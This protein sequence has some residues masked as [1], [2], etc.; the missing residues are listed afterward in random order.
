MPFQK[1]LADP[2]HPQHVSELRSF[3]WVAHYRKEGKIRS[4]G[5][6]TWG[7]FRVPPENAG[8][9]ALQDVVDVAVKAG[10][11]QHGFR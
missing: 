11:L 2:A 7:C 10:G 5:M 1:P 6:A 8:Y 3:S 9:L 4:Y